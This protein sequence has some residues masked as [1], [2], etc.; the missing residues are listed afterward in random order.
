MK[1]L[2]SL[3]LIALTFNCF[4]EDDVQYITDSSV[5]IKTGYGLTTER[6][7]SYDKDNPGVDLRYK[8]SKCYAGKIN[9]YKSQMKALER[10]LY[11]YTNTEIY[12]NTLPDNQTKIATFL[13]TYVHDDYEDGMIEENEDWNDTP[14][15]RPA[16]FLTYRFFH[17]ECEIKSDTHIHDRSRKLGK[18]SIIKSSVKKAPKTKSK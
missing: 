17:F 9:K 3:F 4:A 11:L 16:D 13:V 5:Q 6:Y 12:I 7:F 10:E 15:A 18:D 2:I 8:N 1:C 14:R